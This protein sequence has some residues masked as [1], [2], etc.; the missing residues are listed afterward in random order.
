M[1]QAYRAIIAK[2]AVRSKYEIIRD[3]YVKF[4]A[5]NEELLFGNPNLIVRQAAWISNYL[6]A[7]NIMSSQGLTKG[8]TQPVS[9]GRPPILVPNPIVHSQQKLHVC[10]KLILILKSK[11]TSVISVIPG[12]MVEV[13]VKKNH[14][15]EQIVKF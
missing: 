12:D 11:S 8:Y 14:E 6:C 7:S 15:K 4:K 5:H 9:I 10:R 13:F 3:T 2:I 1:L